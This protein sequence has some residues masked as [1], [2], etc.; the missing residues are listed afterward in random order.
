MRRQKSTPISYKLL[1]FYGVCALV[2]HIL[3]SIVGAEWCGIFLVSRL[4]D[5]FRATLA[6]CAMKPASP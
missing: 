4:V 1:H 2:G 5:L 3:L 6:L